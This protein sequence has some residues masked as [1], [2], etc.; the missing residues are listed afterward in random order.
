VA[1]PSGVVELIGTEMD[2]TDRARADS[3]RDGSAASA[4]CSRRTPSWTPPRRIWP[5]RCRV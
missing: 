4:R 1:N 3:F 2:V 5:V